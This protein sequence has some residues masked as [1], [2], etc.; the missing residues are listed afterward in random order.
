MSSAYARDKID[1]FI[2]GKY[3]KN[4]I[5]REEWFRQRCNESYWNYL[6]SADDRLQIIVKLLDDLNF[7]LLLRRIKNFQLEQLHILKSYDKALI[8]AQLR[9]SVL[10]LA[11]LA[12]LKQ[13]LVNILYEIK[14]LKTISCG[15]FYSTLEHN[16]RSLNVNKVDLSIN[17]IDILFFIKKIFSYEKIVRSSE[18]IVPLLYELCE[19]EFKD[20][21]YKGANPNVYNEPVA[22]AIGSF[23]ELLLDYIDL[24]DRINGEFVDFLNNPW[25]FIQNSREG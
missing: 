24:L 15:G 8:G 3:N 9:N 7:I 19:E 2:F 11:Y 21:I 1:L 25:K 10:K 20:R 22:D 5:S 6:I 13:D 23:H 16:F 17:Y 14:K 4:I 18:D 12:D